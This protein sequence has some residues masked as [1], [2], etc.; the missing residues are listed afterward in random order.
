MKDRSIFCSNEVTL[1]EPLA[2]FR[3]WAGYQK[4]QTL[5][6]SLTAHHLSSRKES[7]VSAES[8]VVPA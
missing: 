2:N 7:G 8:P 1:G 3:M 6:R 4:D 5:T